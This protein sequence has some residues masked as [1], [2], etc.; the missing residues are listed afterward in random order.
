MKQLPCFPSP[1]LF[2]DMCGARLP[3]SENRKVLQGRKDEDYGY[4]E[5]L[6]QIRELHSQLEPG[7]AELRAQE[8]VNKKDTGTKKPRPNNLR[9]YVHN[10]GNPDHNL[11]PVRPTDFKNSLYSF[12]T[13][14]Y[15]SEPWLCGKS[16]CCQKEEKLCLQESTH[17]VAAVLSPPVVKN[18]GFY[19]NR[20]KF[21]CALTLTDTKGKKHPAAC[22]RMSFALL[23]SCMP[24]CFSFT[25]ET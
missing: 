12:P 4:R 23:S 21:L 5:R 3:S 17:N 8:S 20:N 16:W 7:H 19:C 1:V 15:K 24:L 18:S 6:E 22:R 10:F 11:W 14:A 13:A 25:A 9:T 2:I